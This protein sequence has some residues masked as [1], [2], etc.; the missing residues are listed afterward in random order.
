MR[1]RRPALL[2]RGIARLLIR[3]PRAPYVLSDLGD[4][5]DRDIQAGL[6]HFRSQRRYAANTLAS[7]RERTRRTSEGRELALLVTR[8][9][10]YACF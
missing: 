8:R 9:S 6:P 5:F 7:R 3:G 4:A 2:L 10:A 1:G